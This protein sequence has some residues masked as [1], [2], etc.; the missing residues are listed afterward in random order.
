MITYSKNFWGLPHLLRLYGSTIP[1]TLAFAI[2][3]SGLTA[4]FHYIPY[5]GY[6]TSLIDHPY[7]YQVFAL[8]VGFILVFRTNQG[9]TRYWEGCTQLQAMTG[10]L[11]NVCS[12]SLAYEAATV[13]EAQLDTPSAGMQGSPLLKLWQHEDKNHDGVEGAAHTSPAGNVVGNGTQDASPTS[14]PDARIKQV[15]HFRNQILHII[16]LFHGLALQHLRKDWR[17]GNLSLHD[18]ARPPPP[19]DGRGLAKLFP[20]HHIAV[21]DKDSNRG[22][23]RQWSRFY[24]QAYC[25]AP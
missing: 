7:P 2:L 13:A 11:L 6:Y 14:L 22:A 15:I 23:S 17:L 4:L 10:A 9:Y 16:S 21:E 8:I 24:R 19:L 5:Q 18:E 1:R 3:S 20:S 12:L 25:L